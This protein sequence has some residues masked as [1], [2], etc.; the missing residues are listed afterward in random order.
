[1]IANTT[2]P[3]IS[4]T[5][6]VLLTIAT[7]LTPKMLRSVV[8]NRTSH[9]TLRSESAVLGMLSPRLSSSGMR[10]WGTV[11]TTAATVRMPANR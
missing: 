8:L 5:T 3:R 6:P 4:K 2:M 7:S 1:M 10:T 9:A 11:Q